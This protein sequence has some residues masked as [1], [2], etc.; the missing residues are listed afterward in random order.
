MGA[1][2]LGLYL[3]VAMVVGGAYL[4]YRQRRLAKRKEAIRRRRW[5]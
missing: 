4:S 5:S 2:V 3:A 1:G